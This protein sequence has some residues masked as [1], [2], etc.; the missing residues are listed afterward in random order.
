MS[1]IQCSTAAQTRQRVEAVIASFDNP[2][3][4]RM[5]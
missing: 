4:K 1:G 3:H 2:N 5:L